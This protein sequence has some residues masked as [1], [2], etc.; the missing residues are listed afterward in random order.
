MPAII[1]I[2]LVVGAVGWFAWHVAR[3]VGHALH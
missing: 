2:V 1:G 3:E